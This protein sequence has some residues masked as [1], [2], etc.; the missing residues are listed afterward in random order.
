MT[1]VL[2]M[3]ATRRTVSHSCCRYFY[4]HTGRSN[5]TVIIRF[6]HPGPKHNTE[7]GDTALLPLHLYWRVGLS[8]AD[9]PLPLS[10]ATTSRSA[11]AGPKCER[12]S[13][14]GHTSEVTDSSDCRAFS[15]QQMEPKHETNVGLTRFSCRIVL[16]VIFA[17]ASR[18]LQRQT[19]CVLKTGWS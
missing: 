12:G 8:R 13:L 4:A 17:V 15:H 3:R 9:D 18:P 1:P 2:R 14:L 10:V 11:T 19:R 7:H 6:P 16:Y 5:T